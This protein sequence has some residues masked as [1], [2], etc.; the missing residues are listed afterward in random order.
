MIE[1]PALGP[2]WR[3]RAWAGPL[4]SPAE[5]ATRQIAATAAPLLWPRFTS[6]AWRIG[7]PDASRRIESSLG[8]PDAEFVGVMVA[9]LLALIEHVVDVVLGLLEAD[10]VLAQ[11]RA[12]P[13]GDVGLAGV[14][15]RERGDHVA[16]EFVEEVAQVEGPVAD[17]DLGIGEV[18]GAEG[19]AAAQVLDQLG[20]LRGHLHQA[21]R[22]GVGLLVAEAGLGVDHG[23]D[24]V[25]RQVLLLGLLADDVLVAQRQ[26]D[27]PDLLLHLL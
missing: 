26:G 9:V 15:G 10:V 2:S 8:L 13:G 23:G 24:Q 18:V 5:S 14:V 1:A 11:A 6:I 27:L 16:V 25:R 20:G 21:A 22:T 12:A 3:E 19:R 7:R 4:T 17:V